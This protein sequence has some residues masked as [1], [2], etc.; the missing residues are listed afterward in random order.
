MPDII[1]NF[2][3]CRFCTDMIANCKKCNAL[4]QCIECSYS[5]SLFS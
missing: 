5:L 1:N 4:Y 3:Y 2:K